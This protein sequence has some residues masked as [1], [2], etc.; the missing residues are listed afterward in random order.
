[1]NTTFFKTYKILKYLLTSFV[2]IIVV[3]LL[4]SLYLT[5]QAGSLVFDNKVSWASV[6]EFGQKTEF[7]KNNQNKYISIWE[8]ENKNSDEYIIYLHGNAGRLVHFFPELVKKGNVISP[9][10]PGYSESEGAPT[11]ENA[12]ETATVTYNWLVETKKVPE[13]KITIFGHSLGGSTAVYLASQKPNAKQLIVVN[14]FSSIQ[15]MCFRS[16]SILCGFTSEIFNSSKNAEKVTIKV[17]QFGYTGD[18]TIPFEESK[19]LFEYF[20]SSDKKFIEQN[21]FTH[22]YPDFELILSYL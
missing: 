3:W 21:K 12:Y 20:K 8:F 5:G 22:S 19:K 10:Y 18:T 16:Y 2:I 1:M 17:R 11:M 15:S 14:T 13:N 7:I 6:P 4:G 9:A